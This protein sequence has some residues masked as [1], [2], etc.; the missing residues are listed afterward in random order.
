MT[1]YFTTEE[2]NQISALEYKLCAVRTRL[3]LGLADM[4]NF[5]PDDSDIFRSG[6][7]EG[8]RIASDNIRRLIT[9]IWG[10]EPTE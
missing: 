2:R 9:E 1:Q 6:I 10:E 8:Y 7:K 3:E 4:A 5:Q